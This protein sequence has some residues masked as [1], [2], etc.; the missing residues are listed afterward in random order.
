MSAPTTDDPGGV[1]DDY[2][3]AERMSTSQSQAIELRA[4][5]SELT[6]S[7]HSALCQWSVSSRHRRRRSRRS[8]STSVSTLTLAVLVATHEGAGHAARLRPTHRLRA[9]IRDAPSA[10]VSR[11]QV[12]SSA[13]RRLSSRDQRVNA[14]GLLRCAVLRDA[15]VLSGTMHHQGEVYLTD[16]LAAAA[17]CGPPPVFEP[18]TDH[19]QSAKVRTTVSNSLSWARSSTRPCEVPMRLA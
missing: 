2:Y 14:G 8:Q 10:R 18:F 4:Q 7:R 1:S 12:E 19:W 9:H 5:L 3:H 15:P 6:R 13:T 17:P 11:Y 16:V